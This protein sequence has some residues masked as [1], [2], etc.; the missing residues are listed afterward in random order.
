MDASRIV[1]SLERDR[2]RGR[3]RRGRERERRKEKKVYRSERSWPKRTVTENKER[4]SI[5]F[6]EGLQTISAGLSGFE[7][8]K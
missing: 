6:C 8:S 5:E 3:E 1:D 2:E 7:L 4:D